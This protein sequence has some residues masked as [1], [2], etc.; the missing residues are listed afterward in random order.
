M[1][2]GRVLRTP[3][4]STGRP[5]VVLIASIWFCMIEN[6][7]VQ[8]LM[9]VYGFAAQIS[10]FVDFPCT[11]SL[12]KFTSHNHT[13]TPRGECFAPIPAPQGCHK[14][15][16][17]QV[18]KY[19]NTQ[20]HKYTFTQ[21]HNYTNTQVHKYT[22]TQTHKHTSTQAHKCT[23][24]QMH[25]YTTTQIHKHTNTQMHKYTNDSHSMTAV[26]L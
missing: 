17:T 22:T 5:Q 8:S 12:G 14:Y 2:T 24:A 9:N 20:I 18:H 11:S 19:T 25:K 1:P 26:R 15:T 13:Q 10:C 16:S 23:N 6:Q 3:P 4:C 7:D 21:L